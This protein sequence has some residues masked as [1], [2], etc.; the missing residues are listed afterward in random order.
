MTIP[1]LLT[2]QW[3]EE[4]MTI[5]LFEASPDDILVVFDYPIWQYSILILF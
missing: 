3:L 4:E 5:I 1:I 2:D